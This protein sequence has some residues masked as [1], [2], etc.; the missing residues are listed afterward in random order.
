MRKD[1]L[2]IVLVVVAAT[3]KNHIKGNMI[4]HSQIRIEQ[5]VKLKI[6]DSRRI[7]DRTKKMDRQ[8]NTAKNHIETSKQAGLVLD[9]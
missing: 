1:H 7:I 6:K 2:I 4:D 8:V 5:A 3:L 9:H